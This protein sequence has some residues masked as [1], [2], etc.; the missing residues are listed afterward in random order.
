MQ[1]DRN[2]TLLPKYPPSFRWSA[3]DLGAAQALVESQM[4]W[5]ESFALELRDRVEV[6][7]ARIAAMAT[8]RKGKR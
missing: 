7:D 1:S 6:L 3:E 8:E 5:L 2:S 4:R